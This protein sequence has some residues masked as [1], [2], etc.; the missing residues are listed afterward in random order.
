MI[1][2]SANLMPSEAN[3]AE[4]ASARFSAKEDEGI[5]SLLGNNRHSQGVP[6]TILLLEEIEGVRISEVGKKTDRVIVLVKKGA[7]HS[8]RRSRCPPEIHG[9]VL[10][11]NGWARD[12]SIRESAVCLRLIN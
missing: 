3:L 4:R 1:F 5:Y 8:S 9:Y 2:I 11:K 10:G 7:L 12:D 6:G